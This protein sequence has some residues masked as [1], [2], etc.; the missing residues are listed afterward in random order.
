MKIQVSWNAVVAC[1]YRHFG[2]CTAFSFST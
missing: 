2:E 1:R